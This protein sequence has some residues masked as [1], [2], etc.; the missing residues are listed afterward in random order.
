LVEASKRAAQWRAVAARVRAVTAGHPVRLTVAANWGWLNATGG[1]ATNATY[2]DAL[3]IIGVDA[4]YPTSPLATVPQ[5]LRSWDPI[6]ER[7]RNISAA[8][9][10]MPLMLTEIGYCSGDCSRNASSPVNLVDQA[11]HYEAAMLALG[12]LGQF[13]QGLFWWTVNTDP[14]QGGA[15]DRCITP[16]FKPAMGV[17]RKFYGASGEVPVQRGEPKCACY[18]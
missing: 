5:I 17:L 9:G 16:M 11:A 3:D 15:G 4:Y 10:G 7:L 8:W 6:L 13:F 1:Q 2:W 12:T 18:V 14:N